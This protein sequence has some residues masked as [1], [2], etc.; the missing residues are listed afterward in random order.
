KDV[1]YWFAS[2]NV[3]WD[4]DVTETYTAA[5]DPFINKPPYVV[6]WSSPVLRASYLGQ[7]AANFI[8]DNADNRIY[9]RIHLTEPDKIGH[10]SGEAQVPFATGNI[11]NEYLGALKDSD[12]ATQ[13]IIDALKNAGIYNNTLIILGTDH[14]FTKAGH[15]DDPYPNQSNIENV[16]LAFYMNKPLG[17]SEDGIL[18]TT[19]IA[20]IILSVL[21][22]DPRTYSPAFP[23]PLLWDFVEPTSSSSTTSTIST[24]TSS[25]TSTSK[26]TSSTEKSDTNETP[27]NTLFLA[28]NLAFVVGVIYLKRVKQGN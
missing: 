15:D 8:S 4:K 10:K 1:D 26:T 2:E 23:D 13:M 5:I 24:S 25:S 11:T 14:G 6:G 9:L 3:T 7:K 17:F 21:G 16:Q 19:Q 12:I 20:P 22:L 18:S 27:I 28:T